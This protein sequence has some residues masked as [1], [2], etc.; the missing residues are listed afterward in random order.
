MTIVTVVEMPEFQRRARAIMSDAE[1]MELID[2]IA[3]NPLSA[4]CFA[5]ACRAM[6]GAESQSA[7]ASENSV[8]P[9]PAVVK[10]AVTG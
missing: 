7:A 2:F 4:D 1:R 8:L 6:D 10:A 3:R 9:G 5:I